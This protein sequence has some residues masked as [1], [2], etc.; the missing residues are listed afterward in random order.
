MAIDL[1]LI[2]S[3]QF[4][5][6]LKSRTLGNVLMAYNPETGETMELN[7]TGMDIFNLLRQEIPIP[8][9]LMKLTEQYEVAQEDILEDVTEFIER[10]I[11]QG[12][13]SL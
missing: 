7:D 13:I 11:T 4:N 9:I 1:S 6:N 12:V 10:M 8:Q 5:N 2:E 3:Y